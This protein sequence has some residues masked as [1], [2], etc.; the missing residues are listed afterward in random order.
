MCDAAA[1]PLFSAHIDGLQL[2][3]DTLQRL[4]ALAAERYLQSRNFTVLHLLT[5]CHALRLLMPSTE[6]PDL[7]L[8]WYALAYAAGLV[9]SG[10]RPAGA[11]AARPQPWGD[12]IARAIAS[13]N[14]HVVKLVYT[15]REEAA[16]YADDRYRCVATLATRQ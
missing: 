11:T 16:H 6:T 13:D 10:T 14:D 5:S 8:R 15:C 1:T 9:A 7:M 3:P 4:S 2:A 12:V